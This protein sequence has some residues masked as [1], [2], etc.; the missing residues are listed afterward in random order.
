MVNV[1]KNGPDPL[2]FGNYVCH[3]ILLE[4]L[5]A[6]WFG[7]VYSLLDK[8]LAEWLSAESGGEWS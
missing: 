8:A 4:K 6:T 7:C 3:S 1:S 2:L 5:A